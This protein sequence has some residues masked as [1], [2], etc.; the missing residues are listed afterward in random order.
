MSRKPAN[1]S[2][3]RPVHFDVAVGQLL[4][5]LFARH[6]CSSFISLSDSFSFSFFLQLIKNSNILKDHENYL[7]KFITEENG[8]FFV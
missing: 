5:V 2:M 3:N 8:N 6:R 7:K 4:S 1:I